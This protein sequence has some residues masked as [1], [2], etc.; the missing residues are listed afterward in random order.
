[1]MHATRVISTFYKME[2]KSEVTHTANRA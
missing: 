1:M 2:N